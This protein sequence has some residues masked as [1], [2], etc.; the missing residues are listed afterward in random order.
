MSTDLE[1]TLRIVQH[2]AAMTGG[3]QCAALKSSGDKTARPRPMLTLCHGTGAKTT[4]EYSA[5]DSATRVN[6]GEAV[7]HGNPSYDK[8]CISCAS[9]TWLWTSDQPQHH[10]T[11]DTE[12]HTGMLQTVHLLL[13]DGSNRSSQ[14]LLQLMPQG[15]AGCNSLAV[16]YCNKL[17]R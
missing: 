12:E 1:S 13:L 16:S 17:S 5:P 15:A 8:T 10:K 3:T 2:T 9:I 6:N 11:T 7:R 4:A 14:C